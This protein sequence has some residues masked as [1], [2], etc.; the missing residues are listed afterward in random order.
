V[1]VAPSG[2]PIDKAILARWLLTELAA[3]LWPEA[4]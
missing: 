3:H 4:S 2:A 1:A